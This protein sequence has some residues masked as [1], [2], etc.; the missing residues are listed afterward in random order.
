MSNR[1]GERLRG[2]IADVCADEQCGLASFAT[3]LLSGGC[4]HLPQPLQPSPAARCAPAVAGLLSAVTVGT[5]VRFT[6]PG[7]RRRTPL[8]LSFILIG[9]FL[10]VA[11][12][13]AT[14]VGA[15]RYPYELHG[16]QAVAVNKF[17][18]WSSRSGSPRPIRDRRPG[19][20]CA[21]PCFSPRS[22][23]CSQRAR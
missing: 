21:L 1:D 14:Y 12:N 22:G 3:G 13:L 4:G 18:S 6:V 9:L 11:E 7:I 23:L 15:W 19:N 8:A 20:E 17:G 10:W 5:F 2:W 16:R